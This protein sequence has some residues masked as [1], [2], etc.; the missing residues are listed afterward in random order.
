[1]HRVASSTRGADER[2][3]RA[4]VEAPRARA[5]PVR[6]E[7][8][9]GRQLEV[10][11]A[12]RRGR[13]TSRARVDQHRA[14]AE[15]PE[16]RA[17]REVALEDRPRVDVRLARHRRARRARATASLQR[18]QPLDHH[19]VVV[20]A[21]RVARDRA[22]RLAPAVVHRRRRPRSRPPRTAARVSR[23]FSAPRAS[24]GA[25]SPARPAGEPRVE[26]RR[27]SRPAR[28][29]RSRRGRSRGRRP[30][31]SRTS[32]GRGRRRH[33]RR[34][35]AV[36]TPRSRPI[37]AVAR[38]TAR[39]GSRPPPA[40]PPSSSP[41]AVYMRHRT[42]SRGGTGRNGG[43]R[44]QPRARKRHATRSRST[45]S[46]GRTTARGAEGEHETEPAHTHESHG[47]GMLYQLM[48]LVGAAIILAA[49]VA[50][51]RGRMGREDR[52]Y[53]VLNFVG[54]ALLTVGRRRSTD[55]GDSSS[56]KAAGRSCRSGRSWCPRSPRSRRTRN[57]EAGRSRASP[58][59]PRSS[60]G[61]R[62][63]PSADEPEPEPEHE[64]EGEQPDQN[65][66]RMLPF[67]S[68][69]ESYLRPSVNAGSGPPPHTPR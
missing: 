61:L 41:Y 50:Y 32:R 69:H 40:A 39:T 1:M 54:S 20:V 7:R 67:A 68:G 57:G 13:R 49:Y 45:A 47:T 24:H 58:L 35:G 46:V 63:D 10:E 62:A 33:R 6:L 64:G 59:D 43:R 14:L 18:A 31:P 17:P 27:P 28:G 21:A 23:R 19:V 42:Y 9:V 4:R 52:L 38:P 37:T 22:R 36:L 66:T 29:A 34:A 56:S 15:P 30:A 53:N 65:P 3:G 44:H 55:A 60:R 12:A 51:Q 48:S 8:R 11:H 26:R 16:P 5:A 2:V 25:I